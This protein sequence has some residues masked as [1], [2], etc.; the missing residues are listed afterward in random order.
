MSEGCPLTL[1]LMPTPSLETARR[2]KVKVKDLADRHGGVIGVGLTRLGGDYAVKVNLIS[3]SA[4][5][6]P[7]MLDG[8]RVIYEISGRVRPRAV[9]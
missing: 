6:L 7:D 2:V 5:G 1:T 9:R 3:G 8:V 4:K